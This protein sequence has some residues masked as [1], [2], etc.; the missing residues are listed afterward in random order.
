[1]IKIAI[2]GGVA[3]G[4]SE[5]IDFIKSLSYSAISS[6][7][8]VHEL[9]TKDS[10]VIKQVESI[11][12]GATKNGIIDR[13]ALGRIVFT[14][15][16]AM[17]KLETILHPIVKLVRE[18]F[19]Q[20]VEQKGQKIAFCEIPLLFERNLQKEFDLSILIVSPLETRLQ[21]YSEESNARYSEKI[22]CE[23]YY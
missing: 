2:T 4:K 18:A 14:N 19:F 12:R 8:I 16:D 10:K 23:F 13:S 1:M 3:S 11:F 6:D 5:A 17:S 15:P 20:K 9:L 7:S 22:T 21:R